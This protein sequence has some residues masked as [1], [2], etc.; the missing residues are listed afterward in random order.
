M[1]FGPEVFA[2][3]PTITTAAISLI[4]YSSAQGGGEVISDG[5]DPVTSRGVCWS[6]GENPV[7]GDSITTDGSGEGTF[8]SNITE[9]SDST[10]YYVRA[11][12]I[13]S[14]DTA[15]GG[16]KQFTTYKID[17]LPSV[18]TALITSVATDSLG[19]GGNVT[20]DGG[21]AVTARGVCWNTTGNPS[22]S[23]STTSDG[24]G[25]GVFTSNIKGLTAKTTYY[26][27]A[28]ATNSLGT[29]YG[30]ELRISTGSAAW[31]GTLTDSLD[32][33][34]YG[35][36]TIGT[37]NWM[38]RNLA[39]LPSVSPSENGSYGDPYYYIYGY[40]DTVV[41]EAKATESYY[42]YGVLYNWEAAATAC[43]SGWHLPSDQEWKTLEQYLGMNS[44]DADKDGWR[45]S[46]DVGKKLKS[47][48]QWASG[49]DEG[50]DSEEF[51]ALPSGKREF[52]GVFKLRGEFAYFWTSSPNGELNAWGRSLWFAVNA[53]SRYDGDRRGGFPVRCLKD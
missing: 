46:G 29:S 3:L 32:G 49:N 23:D 40:E 2:V 45:F 13:N 43:P 17:E 39:Y 37:Q 12:A 50:I 38:A 52:D 34:I 41:S 10:T 18:T 6:T 5:G 53:I 8:I 15:Y 51:T 4:T 33:Q 11:Y 19:G 35:Y 27:R 42:D 47:T 14:I 7:V 36:I 48:S 44:D 22:L 1:P 31:A 16:Q 28:Y 25:T 21:A 24:V 20:S 30:Y 26:V 9:L